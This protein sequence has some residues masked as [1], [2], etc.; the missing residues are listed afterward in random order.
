[1]A[2]LLKGHLRNPG[3]V[4]KCLHFF[5]SDAQVHWA[6]SLLEMLVLLLGGGDEWCAAAEDGPAS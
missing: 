6:V 5:I 1:M 4:W 3:S 2:T